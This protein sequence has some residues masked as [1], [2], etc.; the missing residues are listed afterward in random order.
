MGSGYQVRFDHDIQ[1]DS[2][3]QA[4]AAASIL[5]KNDAAGLRE[6]H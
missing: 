6:V 2:H 3:Y 4:F 1:Q 5:S